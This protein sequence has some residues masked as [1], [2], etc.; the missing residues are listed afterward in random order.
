MIT[1]LAKVG[2]A[3]TLW[4]VLPFTTAGADA[5]QAPEAPICVKRVVAMEYPSPARMGRIQGRV[6]LAATISS[7]G[8]VARVRTVS[9]EAL[10]A[11]P[12]SDVL[13][14]WRFAGCAGGGCD[15]NV[16]FSFSLSGTCVVGSAC[17]TDFVADL[18]DRVEVRSGVWDRPIAE[19]GKR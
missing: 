2:R 18:P 8:M 15:I 16:T 9:G 7:K 10:L 12:A 11:I 5:N 4:A 3:V 13:S 1:I 6:V 19:R 14:R 17:P